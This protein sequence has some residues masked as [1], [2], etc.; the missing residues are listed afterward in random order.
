MQKLY[1]Y[2]QKLRALGPRRA[3]VTLKHRLQQKK[4]AYKHQLLKA[5]D[6]HHLMAWDKNRNY[7]HNDLSFLAALID[8]I[9]KSTLC[10]VADRYANNYFDVLGSGEQRL[11]KIPWH[12]DI[13]LQKQNPKAD[14]HFDAHT[15]YKNIVI[16]LGNESY[17]AKDIKVPWELARFQY[18]PVL[19]LAYN[20]TYNELYAS[21]AKQQIVSWLDANSFCHGIHWYNGMEVA[22][23]AIN[24]IVAWHWLHDYFKS[25]DAFYKRFLCSLYDHMRYLEHNWEWYDGR[26]NNHYLANIV[27]YAYLCW[28]FKDMPDVQKKWDWCYDQLIQEFDWQIF[29]E[30]SSYEG[31]TKYHI[32]VTELFL[33][34]FLIARQ[35]DTALSDKIRKKI[36]KMVQ[37]IALCKPSDTA[38]PISI[39]DDDSGSLL[40]KEIFN[41]QI[42]SKYVGIPYDEVIAYL[43]DTY[44]FSDFGISISRQHDWHVTLRHQAYSS[45]QPTGH[46]HHDAGNITVAYKGVPI[47]VDPGTYVYTASAY[48]RN[49]FRSA[50]MHNTVYGEL[51]HDMQDLFGLKLYTLHHNNDEYMKAFIP[52]TNGYIQRTVTVA[53]GVIQIM[54]NTHTIAQTVTWNLIFSPDIVLMKRADTWFVHTK[55]GL[56]F[57]ITTLLPLS[58]YDCW[59]SP[60]YGKIL[61]TS[62]LIANAYSIDYFSM[63]LQCV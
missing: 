57:K 49:Y 38:Q 25:D 42:F 12:C 36:Y 61:K 54:D 27:G 3:F 2:I 5:T 24:W 22:I 52:V 55:K 44:Y 6:W 1:R 34:G 26:T 16:A 32:F 29:D 10:A 31:S 23:R 45:R 8:S 20:I 46:F 50:A 58:K 35:M 60:Q 19:G 13:R 47:I 48:W 18:S 40:N 14:T 53:D 39:G 62:G 7:E 41:I 21:V 63:I 37:F 30:G 4:T 15:Y 9:D 59:Y 33:H 51:I 43:P 56:V 11:K 28:F 17:L